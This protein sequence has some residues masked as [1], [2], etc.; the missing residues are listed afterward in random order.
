MLNPSMTAETYNIDALERVSGVQSRTLRHW[1]KRKLL[2]KPIGKGRGAR[3]DARHLVRARAIRHLRSKELSLR[4]IQTRM[5]GLSE[6]QIAALVPPEP[7]PITTEGLPVAPPL[8]SYPAEAWE[9]IPLFDG[10][11]LMVNSSKGPG[12]RRIAGEIY[13]YYNAGVVSVPGG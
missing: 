10:M 3:Y 9:V 5:T 6:Q 4:D 13:R 12:L 1:I 2:P 11:V 7:R 8:P